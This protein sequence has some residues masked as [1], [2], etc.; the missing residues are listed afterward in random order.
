MTHYK[1]LTSSEPQFPHLQNVD[2]HSAQFV[3]LEDE[4]HRLVY[5]KVLVYSGCLVDK[6]SFSG[7]FL[8]ADSSGMELRKQCVP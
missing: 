8:L 1:L 3:G 4:L 6:N 7:A 5:E 2:S